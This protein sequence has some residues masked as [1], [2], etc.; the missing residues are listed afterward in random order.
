M[1]KKRVLLLLLAGTVAL[2]S[3]CSKQV[4][5]EAAAQAAPAPELK[6]A[7]E[8]YGVVEAGDIKN[9]NL[10]FD[11]VVKQIAVKEGQRVK[12]GDVLVELDVKGFLERISRKTHELKIAE[13]E[14]KRLED[15]MTEE[16]LEN[17]TDP[18]IR[19]LANDLKYAGEQ[20]ET[21][22]KE[23]VA[24]RRLL[25]SGAISRSEYDE[26]L[27]A[28]NAKLKAVEDI[29]YSLDMLLHERKLMNKELSDSIA[30]QKEKAA[31]VR[32]EIT[33]MRSKLD[34]GYISEGKIVSDVDNGIVYEIG[35]KPGDSVSPEKKLLSLMNLDTLMVRTDVPEE[36]IKDVRLG[37][38]AEIVPVADK[39]KEYKGRVTAI[40]GK[41]L[42]KNGETVVPVEISIDNK[43]DFL[44]PGFNVD[45]K[46]Y[47]E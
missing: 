39:S 10:D 22:L 1:M 44:L 32:N 43:D 11:A 24:H 26:I 38:D 30:I 6:K 33:E 9:I 37:A 25:E 41:A 2:T 19:K 7:V 36:F 42:V 28:A 29:Q 14:V 5:T 46:I 20:A 45:V 15:K 21:A 13:F 4:N 17:C 23:Q 27:K 31:T 35:Y 47:T 12:K 3:A 40:S 34:K 8:A 18:D 16:E